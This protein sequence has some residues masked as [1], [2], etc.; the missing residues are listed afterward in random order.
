LRR[1]DRAIGFWLGGAL[2]G[3]GGC[4]LGI[5]MPYRHPVAVTISALWWGIYLGCSGAI[6]G[7]LLGMWAE[8]MPAPPAPSDGTPDLKSAGLSPRPESSRF[9]SPARWLHP[10][11][12]DIFRGWGGEVADAVD[13]AFDNPNKTVAATHADGTQV[14]FHFA[15]GKPE[16]PGFSFEMEASTEVTRLV[17]AGIIYYNNAT[18]F[19]LRDTLGRTQD[20]HYHESRPAL[21]ILSELRTA[22][23]G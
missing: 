9:L 14:R 13:E 2:L 6:L 23:Q 8:Q 7:A 20:G 1:F 10:D 22:E 11:C 21:D 12:A 16:Q 5:C 18:E 4:I 17:V 15:T 3:V 19:P